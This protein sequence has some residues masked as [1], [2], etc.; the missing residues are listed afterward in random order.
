MRYACVDI[1]C[2][3]TRLLVAEPAPSGLHEVAAE[4]AFTGIGPGAIGAPKIR[5]VARLVDRQVRAARAARAEIVRVVATAV[6]RRAPDGDDLAAA[7][8]AAS[9]VTVEVLSA[10]EE[11]RLAFA[12]AA[13]APPG[14][15]PGRLAVVD[16]G[17][18]STEIA[19]GTAAAGPDWWA[20]ADVGSAAL[21]AAHLG[22]DPPDAAGLAAARATADAAF[23]AIDV[24]PVDRAVAVGG[25]A[26]SLRR[27]AGGRLDAQALDAA[28]GILAA[29]PCAEV[30]ARY[31]LAPERVRLMPAGLV[32]LAAA[33]AR[34]GTALEIAAGGLREGVVLGLFTQ[35]Q[36]R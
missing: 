7:V 5:E 13:H 3:T 19:V 9:G 1:G 18:G 20:S 31:A 14:A 35:G 4:R 30:A 33:A 10:A 2:N 15:G 36:G 11:A 24:P 23:A 6:V 25:S 12:G 16:V 17:G 21:A 27:L 34:I 26:T 22:G 29:A 8:E 28:V 32:L